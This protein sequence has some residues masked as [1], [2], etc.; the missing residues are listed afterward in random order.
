MSYLDK[1]IKFKWGLIISIIF[2]MDFMTSNVFAQ[3]READV[4][5]NP[6]KQTFV[7]NTEVLE[8][9]GINAE[10][11][12]SLEFGNSDQ[13]GYSV[14][15]DS[16]SGFPVKGNSYLVLST[17][18]T[19]STLDSNYSE[20]TTG[21]L[22]GL[23]SPGGNDMVQMAIELNVPENVDE[24]AFQWKFL[25]EEYPEFVGSEYN[26]GF[27]VEKDISN[28]S[29]NGSEITAPN[30]QAF[31]ENNEMITINTTGELGMSSDQAYGTTYDGATKLLTTRISINPGQNSIKLFF[32]IF[33]VGD[34]SYD[35]VVFLDNF[36]FF[37]DEKKDLEVYG[38]EVNQSIQDW[39][40]SV[41]LVE[42]K[43]T[44]VRA[45]LH[46]TEEDSGAADHIR[47]KATRGGI[48]L[49]ESPL[50]ASNA[51]KFVAPNSSST[52]ENKIE[53]I[54]K[55]RRVLNES[56]Y[57]DLPLSWLNGN[58]QLELINTST[59]IDLSC[60]D[61]A[62]QDDC[63]IDISF[64]KMG[65]P[66]IKFIPIHWTDDG[67]ETYNKPE[68]DYNKE[69]NK[70][71]AMYPVSKIAPVLGEELL[72]S[73]G[74]LNPD[75]PPSANS[76][77]DKLADKWNEDFSN[78]EISEEVVYL[79]F[80]EA[81]GSDI[82]GMANNIPG[83]VAFINTAEAK[84]NTTAHEIG[85]ILGL[86]H[87]VNAEDNGTKSWLFGSKAIG[88]CGEEALYEHVT[89][90]PYT[91]DFGIGNYPKIAAIGP[92]DQ[93]SEK[94]I[95]GISI[96]SML[97]LSSEFWDSPLRETLPFPNSDLMSYCH[98]S[99]WVSD[100][101]YEKL[102]NGINERFLSKNKLLAS[103]SKIKFSK[104]QTAQ[105]YLIIRGNINLETSTANF[106]P[107]NTVISSQSKIEQL[108]PETGDFSLKLLDKESNIINQISFQPN[109]RISK[110]ISENASFTIPIETNTDI[111]S[112][113]I[114]YEGEVIGSKIASPNSPTVQ[115]LGPNGGESLSGNSITINW[116]A[117]DP[118]N[119]ELTYS[120]QFSA[121]NGNTWKTLNTGWA[122]TSLVVDLDGLE[123]T[124]EG[125]IRI[126]ATDGF[127]T[128]EDISDAVFS[129]PNN[130]PVASVSKPIP[131]T[132]YI[133]IEPV[134]F[135]GTGYDLEDGQISEA[136]LEWYS[137]ID[138][139]IGQGTSFSS[140]ALALTKGA[141]VITLQVTDNM[142]EV[143]ISKPVNIN[144][145][146]S[147]PSVTTPSGPLPELVELLQP[148]DGEEDIAID[149][150][151]SW[152]PSD[153]ADSYQLQIS[154]DENFNNILFD[155]T[156][157]TSTNLTID[158]LNGESNYWWR[159]RASNSEG[160]GEWSDKWS[161]STG[162]AT[163]N[164]NESE[165]PR[166]PSL[167]QNY[168]NPFNPVTQIEFGIPK[169]SNVRV[170]IY[171]IIGQKVVTLV[172]ESLRPGWHKYS[173]DAKNL[174]SGI[175]FYR[176]ETG[177]FVETKKMTLIK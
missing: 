96:S 14:F 31:D 40:N 122:D 52:N 30:N 105:Q 44:I 66:R 155:T 64:E 21:Y 4:T 63:S 156:D 170:D 37:K 53:T 169:T 23:K 73:T 121:D 13:S 123:S 9:L 143:T 15:T 153:N 118:D 45:F 131:G 55:R 88:Y 72:I 78:N 90:F 140:E 112:V 135:S 59:E 89:D 139:L 84:E 57:F 151:F 17:G 95:F 167:K 161:F 129:T 168:P 130:V 104:T 136:N 177:S 98:N 149:S 43:A 99:R 83:N 116:T 33:D 163:S 24:I 71:E 94:E 18:Y 32:S 28:F 12:I 27:L 115:V 120:I 165:L 62:L 154:S 134:L 67:G 160:L 47:L 5:Q 137:D 159:V 85:H 141:H 97:A 125:L 101:T 35:S 171:N 56:L 60:S 48:E 128:S 42:D 54:R 110:T 103:F 49:V 19:S 65:I 77:I 132:N 142:G 8:A 150:E 126:Q 173:F 109:I 144:V 22:S 108:Q 133:G 2:L 51:N 74:I 39:E 68:V 176:L 79:G 81:E 111:H 11:I 61:T 46:T 6:L 10:D 3:E 138:G 158:N 36:R 127:N 70:L 20:S 147:K 124:N 38:F 16:V 50:A 7:S 87:A 152:E 164:E 100:I 82:G 148:T 145:Y 76:I 172:S 175:Y 117:N 34:D 119:D 107:F 80:A 113:Q 75:G 1:K 166:K 114:V 91:Y 26:D 146:H 102:K 162:I 157:V 86:R 69:V 29:V 92:Y 58:V 93:G 174:S 41:F 25:S 106:R